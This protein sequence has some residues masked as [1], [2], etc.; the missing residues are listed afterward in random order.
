MARLLW[1]ISGA[2]RTRLPRDSHAN[3]W[4]KIRQIEHSHHGF[5]AY[6]KYAFL[7]RYEKFSAFLRNELCSNNLHDFGLP[8]GRDH[9][10]AVRKKLSAITDRFAAFQA[11]WLNVHVD[12]PLLQ[13]IALPLTIGSVRYPAFKILDDRIIRLL[14]VLLHAGNNLNAWS[15]KQIHQTLLTTFRLSANA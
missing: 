4:R 1:A 2:S 13:G 11:S 6:W 12:F 10:K 15:A 5:L 9:L 14:E 7:K 8:K 3:S